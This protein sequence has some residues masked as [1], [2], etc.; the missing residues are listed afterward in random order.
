MHKLKQQQQQQQLNT[1]VPEYLRRAS[2][3]LPFLLDLDFRPC[4]FAVTNHRYGDVHR[5][6]ADLVE[7]THLGRT[8]TVWGVKSRVSGP[9]GDG[10]FGDILRITDR[11]LLF[12]HTPADPD[13]GRSGGAGRGDPGPFAR[14]AA[15]AFT[16]PPPLG[17]QER[18]RDPRFQGE[19]TETDLAGVTCV[20]PSLSLSISLCGVLA[21]GELAA[22]T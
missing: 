10:E 14:E 11:L 18:A 9:F 22:K 19:F 6:R 16:P 4:F 7:L 8:S 17:S 12:L 1:A 21:L 20:S 13:A 3:L 15:T 5:L 2:R